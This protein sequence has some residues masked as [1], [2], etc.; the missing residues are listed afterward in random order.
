MELVISVVQKFY[1]CLSE[2]DKGKMEVSD[3]LFLEDL[4]KET[5]AN[6]SY[7]LTKAEKAEWLKTLRDLLYRM[8]TLFSS[9]SISEFDLI[10]RLFTEQFKVT[11]QEVTLKKRRK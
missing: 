1:D 11:E 4:M 7:G 5:A 6:H 10:Q 8:V 9:A 3:Q 2:Q